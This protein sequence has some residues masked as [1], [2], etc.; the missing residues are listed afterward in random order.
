MKYYISVGKLSFS[1]I[2][3][4]KI[5]ISISMTRETLIVK[6]RFEREGEIWQNN[7]LKFEEVNVVKITQSKWRRR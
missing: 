3:Q 4:A 6:A 5:S 2:C 7:I 1:F